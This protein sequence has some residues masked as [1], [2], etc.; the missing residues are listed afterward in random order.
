MA[1]IGEGNSSAELAEASLPD[2]EL[3]N[4]ELFSAELPNAELPDAE[5]S[6]AETSDPG[7]TC[8]GQPL[9]SEQAV[10]STWTPPMLIQ[11][12]R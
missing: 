7:W 4:A 9:D 2:T 1:R 5:L 12:A 10:V 3:P 11:D 8:V 6:D